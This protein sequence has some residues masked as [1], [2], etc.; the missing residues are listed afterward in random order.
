[1]GFVYFVQSGT[2]GDIKIGYSINV[3]KRVQT[4]KTA[5]PEGIKLIGFITGDSALEKALHWKFRTLRKN[6]EWFKCDNDIIDY[7]NTVNEM[8]LRNKMDVSLHIENGSVKLFGKIKK[9]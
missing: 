8:K 2:K 7:L 4:L 5:M 3:K 1:M 9:L 6:G